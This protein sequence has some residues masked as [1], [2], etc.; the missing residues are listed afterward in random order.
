MSRL[1]GQEETGGIYR[2]ERQEKVGAPLLKMCPCPGERDRDRCGPNQLSHVP[3]K[4][5]HVVMVQVMVVA[6]GRQQRKQKTG[7]GDR[8]WWWQG[9]SHVRQGLQK[10][11]ESRE[12]GKKTEA[13]A[14]WQCRCRRAGGMVQAGRQKETG[15]K[16]TNLMCPGTGGMQS[17]VHRQCVAR[18]AEKP[19]RGEKSREKEGGIEDRQ[20]QKE[21]ENRDR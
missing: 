10:Y 6:R 1:S 13:E 2:E 8:W 12:R 21:G 14:V 15:A 18:E 16:E 5:S 4:G 17:P 19:K 9:S 20:R 7:R 11:T 3:R